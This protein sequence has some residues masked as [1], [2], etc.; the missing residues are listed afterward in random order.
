M[1]SIVKVEM[2]DGILSVA[3]EEA[4][5]NTRE[6]KNKYNLFCGISSGASLAA[7]KKLAEIKK[8]VYVIILPDSG[9]RYISTGVFDA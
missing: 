7:V 1:P 6:L 5:S 9:D 3:D 4:Y 2:L 8:G